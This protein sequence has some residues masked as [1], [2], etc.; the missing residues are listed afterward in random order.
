M[1]IIREGNKIIKEVVK[2]CRVCDAQFTYH[3]DDIQTDR[4]GQYVVCPCCKSFIA[5]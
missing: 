2:V 3:R 5:V 1:R 4:D